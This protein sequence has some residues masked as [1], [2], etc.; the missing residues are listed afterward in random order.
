[1][2]SRVMGRESTRLAGQS[3][4]RNFLTVRRRIVVWT[5][6][7]SA[8]FDA[9]GWK[10]G[11]RGLQSA[12]TL[13]KIRKSGNAGRHDLHEILILALCS[14]L[15]WPDDRGYAVFARAKEGSLRRFLTLQNGLPSQEGFSGV[16]R[17]LDP[18]PFRACLQR[19]MARFAQA[20]QGVIAM[21]GTFG[22]PDH[23]AQGRRAAA[24]EHGLG[25][26]AMGRARRYARCC[27]EGQRHR[28]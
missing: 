11:W 21:D 28:A 5:S 7:D 13:L 14:V 15:W 17:R 6:I 19:F 3:H 12:L 18:D 24:G 10:M 26:R 25:D 2:S 1:M 20:C 22:G 16:F 23:L 27:R 8:R 9:H 4:E